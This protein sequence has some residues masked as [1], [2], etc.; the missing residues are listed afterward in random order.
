MDKTLFDPT[1]QVTGP[2]VITDSQQAS[3]LNLRAGQA[4][5][6]QAEST[7]LAGLQFAAAEGPGPLRGPLDSDESF[8]QDSLAFSSSPDTG[9]GQEIQSSAVAV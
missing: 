5:S 3:N 7:P 2:V 6:R 8:S 1:L 9:E 4:A